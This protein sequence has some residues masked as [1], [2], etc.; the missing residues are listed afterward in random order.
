MKID[1]GEISYRRENW[2]HLAQDRDQWR[3][4]VNTEVNLLLTREAGN[5]LTEHPLAS[6][7]GKWGR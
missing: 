7:E 5:L 2:V 4:L 1:L 3:V 6:Q